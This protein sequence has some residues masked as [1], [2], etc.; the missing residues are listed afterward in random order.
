MVYRF[1]NDCSH[2]LPSQGRTL[3]AIRIMHYLL[4]VVEEDVFGL[5]CYMLL[6]RASHSAAWITAS[7]KMAI[8]TQVSYINLRSLVLQGHHTYL[9]FHAYAQP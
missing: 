1:A 8:P 7:Q 9:R 5:L 6:D 2:L 3:P 4:I